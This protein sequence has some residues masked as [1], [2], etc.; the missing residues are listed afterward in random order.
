MEH[1]LHVAEIGAVVGG[2][3]LDEFAPAL[4]VRDSGVAEA[5]EELVFG[6]DGDDGTVEEVVDCFL[7]GCD[8]W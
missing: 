4:R 6:L 1:F 2:R 8:G 3:G 5:V 7:R